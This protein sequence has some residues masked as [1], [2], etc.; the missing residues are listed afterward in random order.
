MGGAELVNI[1]ISIAGGGAL[2]VIVQSL[3]NLPGQTRTEIRSLRKDLDECRDD[4]D[5][6]RREANAANRRCEDLMRNLTLAQENEGRSRREADHY[7]QLWES[8]GGG[9]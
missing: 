9:R 3:F 5:G 8:A 7:K 1:A 4:C 6:C 2:A